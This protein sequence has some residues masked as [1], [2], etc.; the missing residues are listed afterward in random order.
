MNILGLSA[1][2]HDS[3]ACLVQNGEIIAAVQE[4]RFSRQ[5]YDKNFPEKSIEW[6]LHTAG[7]DLS[8]ID[9]IGFYDDP[10]LK[11][12]RI[13]RSYM[14]SPFQG[15]KRFWEALS[16]WEG[17]DSPLTLLQKSLQKMGKERG[18]KV[19]P[20]QFL[21]HHQSH[22]ASAYFP[23][24]FSDAA[25]LVV[26]GVGEFATTSIWHGQGEKLQLIEQIEYPNSLGM[27]YTA[28]TTYLGFRANADEYKVM[29]LAPFGKPVYAEALLQ[30][31]TTLFADGSYKV[32][33]KYFNDFVSYE[34]THPDLW[35]L[36]G[37]PPRPINS[38]LNQ[39]YCDV[40]ASVQAVLEQGML[41]L[42]QRARDVT[43][44]DKLCLAGGV[45]LNCVANGKIAA[46]RTQDIWIQ[47]AS[48]DA[49]GA[50]GAA[51]ALSVASSGERKMAAPDAMKGSLL[52]PSYSNF[53]IRRFLLQKGYPYIPL[54]PDELI[55]T[56]AK[57]LAAGKIIGF[58]D[59]RMEFGP[60]ALGNRSI[61]ADPRA[62]DM[63]SNVN[64]KI[65]FRESFRPFAPIVLEEHAHEWFDLP[66]A[67]PYMLLTGNVLEKH[68]LRDPKNVSFEQFANKGL[69]QIS[70]I[71]AVTHVN[72]TARLQ[73][74]SHGSNLRLHSL[75]KAFA[76]MTGCPILLNTSFNVRNEPIVC[77]P[78]DA[79]DSFM[80]TDL[81]AL[82]L[83]DNLICKA[84]QPTYFGAEA[85]VFA[86]SNLGRVEN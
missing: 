46:A 19:P 6:I 77:T 72:G 29:G 27:F 80:R 34:T 16:R 15:R 69:Q 37:G 3:A 56:A 42:A 25:V 10:R 28:M 74:V 82:F 54:L 47:P 55:K 14:G 76:E 59:G 22:A 20:I 71:P 64:L 7:L 5:C 49:G 78:E 51:L 84:D 73:T 63:Q 1:F 60:R 86:S 81:D 13:V 43:G 65:K 32:N 30:N 58:F 41:G 2:Y 31:V 61:I 35:T 48:G 24:P 9:I 8:D 38:P 23:S 18:Q 57:Y 4:E 39:H 26:D 21:K 17:E 45:A 67:S 75:L 66:I 33:T 68:L 11:Y 79:Y 44:S 12:L 70:T 52:G 50:L 53:D 36:L 62:A 40:A 83:G 85:T